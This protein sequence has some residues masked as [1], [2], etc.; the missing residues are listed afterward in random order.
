MS[1]DNRNSADDALPQPDQLKP[2]AVEG[3][4]D[5]STFDKESAHVADDAANAKQSIEEDQ[6]SKP[7]QLSVDSPPG[8]SP[9]DAALQ[10]QVGDVLTSEVSTGAT[11]TETDASNTETDWYFNSSSTP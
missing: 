4:Q 3:V 7:T 6:T 10:K 11:I 1:S 2:E 5:G 9:A 8:P